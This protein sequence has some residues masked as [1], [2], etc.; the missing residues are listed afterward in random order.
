MMQGRWPRTS[1]RNKLILAFD[2]LPW[3]KKRRVC[4]CVFT[5][6]LNGEWVRAGNKS[7]C[8]FSLDV[9]CFSSPTMCKISHICLSTISIYI[10]YL[11][12]TTD[13]GCIIE[14]HPIADLQ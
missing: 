5:I 7:N 6:S 2:C 9:I 8:D 11:Q 10:G 4:L 13:E 1:S 14:N 12:Q 3:D